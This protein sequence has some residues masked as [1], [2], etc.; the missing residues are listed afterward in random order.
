MQ[1]Y[2]KKHFRSSKMLFVLVLPVL[3]RQWLRNSVVLIERV[4]RQQDTGGDCWAFT[5]EKKASLCSC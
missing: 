5:R 3:L 1:E 2:K 4:P